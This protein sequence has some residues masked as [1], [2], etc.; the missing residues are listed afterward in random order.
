MVVAHLVPAVGRI[1]NRWLR[2][3]RLA[4]PARASIVRAAAP[5]THPLVAVTAPDV[6]VEEERV[7]VCVQVRMVAV[8]MVGV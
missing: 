3:G 2:H 4:G 7:C 8:L 5:P 1:I 6:V